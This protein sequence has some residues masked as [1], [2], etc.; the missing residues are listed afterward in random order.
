MRLSVLDQ[1][2]VTEH[3]P[4]T[5]AAS[6]ALR[7]AVE[8]EELGYHRIWFAEHHASATFAGTAPEIMTAL[9]LERTRHIRVGTGGILLPLYPVNKVREVVTLLDDVHPGRIDLGVGRAAFDDPRYGE[10]IEVLTGVLG[11]HAATEEP[12]GRVWV[13]GAGGSA[14]ALAGTLGAGYA[15]GHFFVP[16]GGELATTAYREAAARAGRGAHTLLAVRAVTAPTAAEAAA[17]ARAMVWWRVRKDLGDE[18]PVPS[19]ER[20]RRHR[21]TE[22]ERT[23]AQ[24]RSHGVVFGTPQEVGVELRALAAAHGADEIVVNTLVSDP[25]DRHR[26]YRLLAEEFREGGHEEPGKAD[27]S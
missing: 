25:E 10:K 24:A 11:P 13:L 4:C 23:R 27:N 16:R 3:T 6:S 9:A 1:V 14:A 26:S 8:A 18:R 21:W 19:V 12:A 7:L 20:V 17:L 5:S 15:H 22:A 2:P